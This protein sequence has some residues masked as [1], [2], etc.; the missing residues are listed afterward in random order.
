[1]GGLFA[2]TTSAPGF[3]VTVDGPNG[4]GKTAL[5]AEMGAALARLGHAVHATAQPSP[6][7]LGETVRSSETGLRGRALA[8]LVAA[9]RHH[10]VETEIV[11]ALRR[12]DV[13]ICDRYVESSL[14][15][16]R[17]DGVSVGY[18]LAINSGIQRPDVR[19]RLR[20]DEA[21]LATRLA[22]RPP[23]AAR[24]FERAEGAPARELAFYEQAD[25]LLAGDHDL[26]PQL[27]DTTTTEALVLGETVA[28]MVHQRFTERS[29]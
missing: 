15:L 23:D 16:Q 2:D 20:A 10:Q 1:M 17:L 22:S 29:R 8:C 18:I 27:Y 21:V 12:G 25:E 11:P 6:T 14:V 24:R 19:V 13:V 28:R 5:A 4:S 9:D 3:F 26:P 7:A